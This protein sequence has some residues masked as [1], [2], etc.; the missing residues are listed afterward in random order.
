MTDNPLQVSDADAVPNA[1]GTFQQPL[2][3]TT[4][5]LKGHDGTIYEIP[6]EQARQYIVSDQRMNELGHPPYP[7]P[8]DE[9]MGHHKIPGASAGDA[10][11]W[12][13][14]RNWEYGAYFDEAG[15]GFAV[16]MHRHPYG[17]ERAIA[18]LEGD[19]S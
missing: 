19:F 1:S 12:H 8:A 15:G 2:R 13:F 17:D 7:P 11:G 14:H 6:E 3:L 9:V 4:T 5:F 10:S 16:G 18:A